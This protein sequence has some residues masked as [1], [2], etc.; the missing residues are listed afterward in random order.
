MEMQREWL[1]IDWFISSLRFI[2]FA[3]GLL[4]FYL[5]PHKLS[6]FP[7]TYFVVFITL[8][9]FVPHFFW[10]PK[11]KN[12]AL[13]F[14]VDFLLVGSFIL[15]TQLILEAELGAA[16]VLM[17]ALTAGYLA[18]KQTGRWAIPVF[19]VLLPA[20]RYKALG[21]SFEFFMQ[22]VDIIIFFGFGISL[23][24]IISS[25]MKAKRLLQENMKQYHL[26]QQQ[27]KV[28]EQYAAQIE[29]V[30]L[31]EERNRLA[32]ELHDSIGHHFT[33]V[34]V[35]LDALSY[36]IDSNPA[37]AKQKAES[38]AQVSRTGLDAIR[39]NIH[40][41]APTDNDEL[42]WKQLQRVA[43]DFQQHAETTVTFTLQ[44]EETALSPQIK[45]TLVRCLQE[46]LTNAKRHGHATKIEVK[47]S[48]TSQQLVLQIT[49]DGEALQDIQHGFGLTGMRNRLEE[50][51]GHLHIQNIEKHVVVTCTIPLKGGIQYD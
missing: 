12:V 35:G 41:I 24:V 49:N 18:T 6:G 10:N 4:F 5:E 13:F 16:I 7:Y 28:L 9:Y 46:A 37:L 21:F 20:T 19:V 51:Q 42:L 36:M 34:I 32:R 43:S 38:L 2:W 27:N 22:Y 45:L 50:L 31:L 17:S 26:I 14:L 25:H 8:A 11:Y 30:T 33:S 39:K 44:G 3:S 40:Q 48:I 1:W 23:N 29:G 47:L 15:Y